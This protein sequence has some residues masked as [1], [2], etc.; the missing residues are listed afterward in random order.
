MKKSF[1]KRLLS[2]VTSALLAV[3]S[4]I[5]NVSS[6]SAALPLSASAATVGN[7]VQNANDGKTANDGNSLGEISESDL[8]VGKGSPLAAKD[9]T[10]A[11][12]IQNAREKYLLGIASQFSIFLEGDLKPTTADAEGRVAVGGNFLFQGAYNYQVGNG[13]YASSTPL[14][15]LEEYKGVTNFAHAIVN[16]KIKNVNTLALN[17][18]N[19]YYPEDGDMYKRLVLQDSANFDTA[20]HYYWQIK[21]SSQ[22]GAWV[23]NPNSPYTDCSDH[24]H[25]GNVRP[26]EKAAFYLPSTPLI[27][28]KFLQN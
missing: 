17:K 15:S 26:N 16:G 4:A 7:M 1:K 24:L 10:A 6:L 28:M 12:A 27:L 13:D 2:G 19:K 20:T 23:T 18:E 14:T 9:G 21:D 11:T 5:P 3:S 8:L 25:E 22:E